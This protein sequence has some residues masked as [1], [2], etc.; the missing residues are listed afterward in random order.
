MGPRCIVFTKQ[1]SASSPGSQ[2]FMLGLINLRL[3]K[4]SLLGLPIW[5]MSSQISHIP[6]LGLCLSRLKSCSFQSLNNT[7]AFHLFD[8]ICVSC[9]LHNNHETAMT[10]VFV[11]QICKLRQWEVKNVPE[12]TQE[13]IK[14]G[15]ELRLTKIL[16]SHLLSSP[17]AF[18]LSCHIWH[19]AFS[20][21]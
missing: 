10:I 19:H 12:V 15:S 2:T 18:P 3:I 20:S 11:L 1:K 9:N 16:S 21:T 13:A 6:V 5:W 4:K 17:W 8:N 7:S 14:P